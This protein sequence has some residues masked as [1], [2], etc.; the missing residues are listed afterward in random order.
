VGPFH[1]RRRP[2][3]TDPLRVVGAKPAAF[4]WW[5]FELLGALPDDHLTDL[6][7]GSGGVARAWAI[8]TGRDPRV[9]VAR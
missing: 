3:L 9:A 8:Y 6:F 7:P 1:L 5:M 4:V 2:R